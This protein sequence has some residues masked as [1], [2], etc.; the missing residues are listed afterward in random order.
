MDDEVGEAIAN[1]RMD[2]A[3][4]VINK[5]LQQLKRKPLRGTALEQMKHI[6]QA[7]QHIEIARMKGR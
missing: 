7:A 6:E 4:Y 5:L 2:V 1:E 3:E